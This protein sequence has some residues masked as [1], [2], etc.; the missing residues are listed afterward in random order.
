MAR[1]EE[2]FT[3]LEVLV[4]SAIAATVMAFAVFSMGSGLTSFKAR[5]VLAKVQA[6]FVAAREISISQQRD[7]R[8]TFVGTNRI[9]LVRLDKPAGTTI[10]GDTQFE[11]NMQFVKVA[12]LPVV[13][14]DQWGGDI[15]A[16]AFAPAAAVRFRSGTGVLVDDATLLPV[17]GRVFIAVPNRKETAGFVSVFGATGRVRSY[18]WEGQWVY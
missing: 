16:I 13:T 11:S 17:N 4:V 3:L 8:I 5:G 2:G 18:H 1:N 6:Q 14:P 7:V 9:Q 12:G 15:N 10:V